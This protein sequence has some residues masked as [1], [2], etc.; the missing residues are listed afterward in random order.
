[1][2]GRIRALRRDFYSS[3]KRICISFNLISSLLRTHIP[4]YQLIAHSVN[5]IALVLPPARSTWAG[6]PSPH[7]SGWRPGGCIVCGRGWLLQ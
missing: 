4:S 1:V 2:L 3:G 7:S 6:G 5:N